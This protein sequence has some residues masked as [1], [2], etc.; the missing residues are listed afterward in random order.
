[1]SNNRKDFILTK[2]AE[3]YTF[4]KESDL[5]KFYQKIDELYKVVKITETNDT[6][7]FS[8][9]GDP[10]VISFLIKLSNFWKDLLKEDFSGDDI[11]KSKIR[12]C[13]YLK[14]WL[15]DKLIINGFNEYDVNMIS[16]FLKKNKHGYMTAIISGKP[17]NF[18]KLSLKNILKIKN[19]YDYYELLY[20]FDMKHYDDISK[21]K[22][23]L[24]YFKNGLDLYKNS[25]VLCHSG[26][27]SEYCYEFNKYSHAY[28]NGRA[29]SDT[30]SCKEKLLS[31]LYKKDTTPTDGKTMNTIDQGLY[32]LLQ[33]DSIV[34]GT[35]LNKFYELL[36]KHYG[37]STSRNCDYLEK[38]S[39]KDK[40]VICE[41]LEV[42][43]N[44]LEK[45]DDTYAKYE[46][47]N[48][49]KTCTYLN[50]WLYDKLLYKDASPCDID[51]FYYLWYKLYID[52]SERKYKCSN[53]KYYGFTKEELDN[54][55]KLFDFLEYYNSIKGKLKEH[56]DE[57]K[58][59]Y[60]SYLKV[61]FELYKEMEQKNDPHTYKDEI[62]LF[63]SIFFDNK[64]LHFLEEKCPD[65]C[66][67]LVFSD[68][69]KTLCP[70][71]KMAKGEFEKASLKSCAHLD[72]INGS[73]K[74]GE[75]NEN[76]YN[77]SN[78]ST[79]T[80]YSE[81]NGDVTSDNYYRICSKLIAYNEKNCGIYNLCNKL[82]RNLIQLSKMEK[83]KRTDRCEYITHWIYDNIAKILNINEKNIYDKDALS[84]F[85]HVG[86]DILNKLDI[87]DCFYNT[88]NVNFEEQ[89]EKKHLHDYFKNYGN[90][91][92]NVSSDNN[93]CQK[94]CEYVLFINR[95]YIKYLER[96]CDCFKSEGCKERYPYYFK[97]DDNYNPHTLFEKLECKNFEQLSNDFK[98]VT[99]PIPVDYHVKLLAEISEVQ[100]HLI[101]WDNKKS[102]II[103]EVVSDKITSDPFH[104]FSL[105][106]FGFLGV[107]LILFMLYKFTPVGSYFNNRDTINKDSYF[108]NFENQYLEDDVEFN[109]SNTQNRRMRIAYH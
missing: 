5:Y 19:L 78:L 55:K 103:P 90:F 85:F 93:E 17:C 48:P 57:K 92:C 41:L 54:K 34:N 45:W 43:K 62:E 50:Y 56:K 61:I 44:I 4:I 13:T 52:K 84:E 89:R 25:K 1:M 99:S 46:E 101:S 88:V 106:S 6:S 40:S 81:L 21:D 31:S 42:V 24:L 32:E 105:G 83:K 108:E 15:Y 100:P 73:G 49:N 7:I 47:L 91:N 16:D 72:S 74:I 67:G 38:Y 37:V 58:N 53:E 64:E 69:Y 3:K 104:T 23:Y 107:F 80:V 95:L 20:D 22:E 2:L 60:C 27:Q 109:H 63:R 36:E 10:D 82:V 68:K 94:Y 29:K 51:M 18:Y 9:I 66:L 98:I 26:K 14:Y 102:S 59:K 70:F 11:A 97:C 33:K 65:L 39:I 75:T 79:S 35:K 8:G 12:H 77:F 71:E 87:F 86:Y 76:D 28:N 96:S 30:L